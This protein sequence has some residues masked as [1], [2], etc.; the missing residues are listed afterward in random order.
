M[1]K[2]YKLLRV[3]GKR[4]CGKNRF[5]FNKK[6]RKKRKE[7]YGTD[8]RIT[9]SLLVFLGIM[10]I[11]FFQLDRVVEIEFF[12][13]KVSESTYD[14]CGLKS[15]DC[16]GEYKETIEAKVTA[17]N[18]VAAQTDASPCIAANGKNICGKDNIVACPSKY[19]LGTLVEIQDK[20]YECQDRM[21][22]Q[23][24]NENRFD[25]SMDKNVEGAVNFGSKTLIVKVLK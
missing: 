16:E 24:R 18:T 23:Y 17:Y 14:P 8:P 19:P 22:E 20:V 1:K 21:A 15:V 9:Y 6:T 4:V 2:A 11:F 10:V 13:P 12:D 7:K 3:N 25:I 5:D